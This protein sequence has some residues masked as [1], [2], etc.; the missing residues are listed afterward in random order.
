MASDPDWYVGNYE[1]QVPIFV[2]TPEPP[3]T[4]PKQDKHLTFTFVS[5]GIG[6]AIAQAAVAPTTRL[7]RSLAGRA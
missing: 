4:P 3:L 7:S 5:D 1:F 2:V 6:A